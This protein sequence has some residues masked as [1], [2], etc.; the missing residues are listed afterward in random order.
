MSFIRKIIKLG[1]LCDSRDIRRLAIELLSLNCFESLDA[2]SWL[3][4][5]SSS[6]DLS[7]YELTPF[8][9]IFDLA[10]DDYRRLVLMTIKPNPWLSRHTS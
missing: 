3:V 5:V 8:S 9:T 1:V 6:S 2:S 10:I 7:T 4:Q